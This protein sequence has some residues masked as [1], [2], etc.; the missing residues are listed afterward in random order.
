[1]LLR[2]VEIRNARPV[3]QAV[4]IG[5]FA[6]LASAAMAVAFLSLATGCHHASPAHVPPRPLMRVPPHP[7]FSICHAD[8]A[9][10]CLGQ[11]PPRSC[12]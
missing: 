8:L 4:A 7:S 12:P 5:V 3:A 6:C 2:E 9:L 10:L 1:M 11:C